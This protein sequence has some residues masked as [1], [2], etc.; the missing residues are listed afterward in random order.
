MKKAIIV[1]SGVAGLALSIRLARAGY[2]VEVLEANSYAGGKLSVIEQEGYRFDAGP[3][4]FTLPA[5]VEEL[6]GLCGETTADH[7]EYLSLEEVC[8]YF[9]EDGTRLQAWANPE[10]LG[11]EVEQKLGVAAKKVVKY[12]EKASQRYD[13]I[14]E[15]FLNRSMQSASTYLNKKAFKAYSQLPSLGLF[16]TLDAENKKW[17]GEQPK[18]V[19]LFNR[20]ATYNGSSP[21]QTP[22][23]MSMI[24]HLEH[25]IGAFFPKK[26]MNSI[27]QSL[28]ALAERQGVV[29]W[30]NKS[31]EK[32]ET[33]DGRATAVITQDGTT[34]S[35]DLIGCNM[36]MVNAYKTILSHEK[37]P[38]KLLRQ[39]KSSSAL[40][41]YWGIQKEFKE[42]ILHNIFFS[43]DYEH[44]FNCI[45][46]KK[47]IGS[48]P[49]VYVN[50]TSKHKPDDAP[51]G[52]ENWFVMINTPNN[53]G[54][55]WD[56]LITQARQNILKK[57]NR[58]LACDIEP[59]IK[60]ESILE[61]RT[62]ESRTSSA[63]GALYGNSS[64]NKFT[65]FLRH[66]NYS[67]Y[68]K[69]LY[70]C[71]GSVHPGGGIP[72]SIMSAKLVANAV[73]ERE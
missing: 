71:G 37:Q 12:L 73:K 58:L 59:L 28:V 49:T 63:Q 42:L 6:F 70:F 22:G 48:D 7:F 66:P 16:N 4:L 39:P 45:F 62:I 3:S 27:T 56:K 69:G 15:L 61:P 38:E 60:T 18:L 17:F 46:N 43:E 29:F 57:L 32:I 9:Y 5:L 25:N 55:D 67:P 23:V 34:Y 14:G 53:S 50:I 65:A 21:Y 40:I 44:E 10:K 54:Q 68:V 41:F 11:Q 52:C 31:V 72:L 26:G 47:T 20:Y 36:D 2:H 33:K 64:N 8:R 13:L 30:F 1:G 35:A 24:P 19:Q 51:P